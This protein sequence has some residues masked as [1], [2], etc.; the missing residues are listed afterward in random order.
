MTSLSGSSLPTK[1]PA[2]GLLWN[3]RGTVK[4]A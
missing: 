3:D 1:A 2:R 4:I